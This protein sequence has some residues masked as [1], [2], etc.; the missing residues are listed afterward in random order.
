FVT[1]SK[2]KTVT[3]HEIFNNIVMINDIVFKGKRSVEW[4]DVKSYLKEYVGEFYTIAATGD[5]IYIGSDL[6]N[7]YSGSKYTHSIKSANA[8][9]KANA[10]QGIPE[11]IEIAVGKHFRENNEEKH[12][13]NAKYGWYRYDSRFALPVYDESGDIERYNVFQASLIVRH[14]EDE[15]LY[16]Y[17]ILDTKK[18]R[19]T[20]LSHKAVHDK[21]PISL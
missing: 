20:R 7:E 15:R 1:A 21:K 2:S 17:D 10:A 6:P 4:K 11:L 19:A 13:R 5:V 9:A 18:K 12:W 8:K 16:L 3:A 14:S